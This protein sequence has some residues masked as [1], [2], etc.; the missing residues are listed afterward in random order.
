MIL[1]LQSVTMNSVSLSYFSLNLG[2][3]TLVIKPWSRNMMPQRQSSRPAAPSTKVR[4]AALASA[5]LK[6]ESY[7]QPAQSFVEAG[8]AHARKVG[9]LPG[10]EQNQQYRSGEGCDAIGDE[11][12]TDGGSGDGDVASGDGDVVALTPQEVERTKKRPSRFRPRGTWNTRNDLVLCGIGEHVFRVDKKA[13]GLAD[14][15]LISCLLYLQQYVVCAAAFPASQRVGLLGL[16]ERARR[17]Q[18]WYW[19]TCTVRT[20]DRLKM[21]ALFLKPSWNKPPLP[22]T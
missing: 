18:V 14:G 22:D 7:S 10:F 12:S 15:R 19:Y 9:L 1:V 13:S 17:D 2:D 4:A 6:R 3:Q 21:G 8:D 20:H 11:G 16:R 5:A